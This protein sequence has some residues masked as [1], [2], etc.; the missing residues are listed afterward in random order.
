MHLVDH[1]PL[2]VKGDGEMAEWLRLV[3]ALFPEDLAY[4]YTHT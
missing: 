1:D 4:R 2:K 3:V